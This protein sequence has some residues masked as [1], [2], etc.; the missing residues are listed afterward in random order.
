MERNLQLLASPHSSSRVVVGASSVCGNHSE[1]R[2]RRRQH[3]GHGVWLDRR[4]SVSARFASI[5][6]CVTGNWLPLTVAWTSSRVVWRGRATMTTTTTATTTTA[7]ASESFPRRRSVRLQSMPPKRHKST[8][9]SSVSNRHEEE[10]ESSSS[11]LRL[12]IGLLADIQYAPIPDGYS[13]SGN[14]RYYRN[15]LQVAEVAAREFQRSQADVVVNLGDI[16]DGKCQSIATNGGIPLPSPD[17][18]GRTVGEQCVDHV[19][20]A[21]SHYQHG[22]MIHSY[23]NH[24]LYNMDRPV[25]QRKLRI[26]FVQE[27]SGEWVGYYSYKLPKAPQVRFVVLD[28]YDISLLQRCP[29]QSTKRQ[30]AVQLLESKNHNYPQAENSPEGLNG[31]AQRYVAFNGGVGTTQLEWLQKTLELA[32]Q[33]EETVLILS[34]QP[35]LPG[36]TKPVCL[37]WNY[38]DVLRVL[39]SYRDV[40]AASFSGHAHKGGYRRDEKSGIHFRVVEAVLENPPPNDTFALLSLYDNRMVVEGFGNCES[41]EYTLDHL[42]RT[43]STNKTTIALDGTTNPLL[44]DP[45][46]QDPLV[47]RQWNQTSVLAGDVAN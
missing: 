12:K 15:A 39:R 37:V 28:T 3:P 24:C 17:D 18:R 43:T 33:E 21:L 46:E 9:V 1:R 13:Y 30:E 27:S 4:L 25:M 38:P 11:P 40:V 22:P 7:L 6:L 19:L 31:M 34:H 2:Q 5:I 10:A 20:T 47:S 23:G 26:P 35:L 16:V 36:S 14:P 41:A 32:R 8:A 29:Q 44:V 42:T 45:T